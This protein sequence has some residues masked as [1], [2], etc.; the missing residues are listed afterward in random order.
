MRERTVEFA[1]V[2]WWMGYA[3]AKGVTF[4]L[5]A[6]SRLGTHQFLYGLDYDAELHSV[7]EYV[8]RLTEGDAH[9]AR[10]KVKRASVGG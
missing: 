4:H 3:E 2:S 7:E 5:P 8:Q 6:F 10:L 1:S 9:E